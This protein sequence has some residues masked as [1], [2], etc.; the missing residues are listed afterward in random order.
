[1]SHP[2]AAYTLCLL[3]LL[4]HFLTTAAPRSLW[5]ILF[6]AQS[7][8]QA[9]GGWAGATRP[10][11]PRMARLLLALAILAVILCFAACDAGKQWNVELHVKSPPSSAA[12]ETFDPTQP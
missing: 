11:G 7:P 8:P 12:S 3:S 10:K 4:W 9:A 5:R 2:R 6:K 1:M